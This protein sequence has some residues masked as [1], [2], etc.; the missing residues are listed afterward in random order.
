MWIMKLAALVFTVIRRKDRAAAGYW[1]LTGLLIV[2]TIS[3][4]QDVILRQEC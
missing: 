2:Q 1:I 4:F 3:V